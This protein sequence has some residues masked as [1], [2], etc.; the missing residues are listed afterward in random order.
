[1]STIVHAFRRFSLAAVVLGAAAS[2]TAFGARAADDTP[3]VYHAGSLTI[4]QPWTRATPKGAPVA[5]GYL[6]IA[7]GGTSADRLIGTSFD[8]AS[9]G[10]VHE[11]SMDNGVMRMRELPKG[12][13]I[14]A[15]GTVELKPG[16][17]HLM[18]VGL[19]EQVNPGQ[20]I[21]GTLV[22]EKAGSVEV[23]FAAATMNATSP[24][25]SPSPSGGHMDHM[26]GMPMEHMK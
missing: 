18:F 17:Y 5:G 14:P 10:E 19:K 16:G 21:K 23:E 11:M 12:L 15:G 2:V 6:R 24:P 3:V 20:K 13:E 7:N 9:K 25:G 22:F 26:Q 4:S 8:I 1:M